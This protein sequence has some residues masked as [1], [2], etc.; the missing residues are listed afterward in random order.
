VEIERTREALAPLLDTREA[1]ELEIVNWQKDE[2]RDARSELLNL[3]LGAARGRYLAFLDY[4]DLL[5]PEAYQRLVGQLRA[6]EAAIAFASVRIVRVDLYDQF[7]FVR[8]VQPGFAGS[9]LLHLFSANFSPLHSFAIDRARL[10]ASVLRFDPSLTWEEDYELLLRIC[11]SFKSDFSLL[12]TFIGDYCFKTDG[13]NSTL[14]DADTPQRTAAYESVRA[15]MEERRRQIGVSVD[16]QRAV[17]IDSP[18]PGMT[19]SDV[20][21][22]AQARAAEGR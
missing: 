3:G 16:V 19:I 22:W 10:P 1:P 4:D 13:S 18:L 6:S 8:D 20:L 15:H 5:Y 12:G 9:S 14:T 17:G 11:A 2:P 7:H 21:A